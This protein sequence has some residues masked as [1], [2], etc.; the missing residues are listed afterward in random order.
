MVYLSAACPCCRYSLASSSLDS[1]V[2]SRISGSLHVSLVSCCVAVCNKEDALSSKKHFNA[3]MNTDKVNLKSAIER[4]VAPYLVTNQCS[5]ERPNA[6]PSY[7]LDSAPPSAPLA[8]LCLDRN[9]Q[10]PVCLLS[11]LK[12]LV[13]Q[14]KLLLQQSLKDILNLL[15]NQC[16][17]VSSRIN[18]LHCVWIGM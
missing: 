2:I 18:K 15:K 1:T 7:F 5:L 10:S 17:V 14:H 4:S 13:I 12:N 11:L 3:E 9:L 16:N 8:C 6:L